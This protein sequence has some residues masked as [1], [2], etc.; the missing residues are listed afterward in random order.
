M[1]ISVAMCN[2]WLL[3]C[4]REEGGAHP[5]LEGWQTQI[6]VGQPEFQPTLSGLLAGGHRV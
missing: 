6:R 2:W 4:F 1:E 5:A 3:H